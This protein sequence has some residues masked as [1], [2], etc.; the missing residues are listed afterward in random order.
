[1]P[2]MDNQAEETPADAPRQ[3]VL[4]KRCCDALRHS[5]GRPRMIRRLDTGLPTRLQSCGYCHTRTY[6][7]TYLVKP[8]EREIQPPYQPKWEERARRKAALK[9]M[10][11]LNQQPSATGQSDITQQH[12]AIGQSN[13]AQQPNRKDD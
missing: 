13:N 4:C 12:S 8:V 6:C 11:E 10:N 3:M 5:P 7:A 9:Q 1:M 2:G